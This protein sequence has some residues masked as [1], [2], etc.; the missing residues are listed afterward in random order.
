MSNSIAEGSDT[1]TANVVSH[2][3]LSIIVKLY[4]PAPTPIKSSV[5]SPEFH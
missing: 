3:A 5:R 4:V 1:V 2:P